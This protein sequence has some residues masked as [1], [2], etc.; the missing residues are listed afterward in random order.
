VDLFS[1]FV[2]NEHQVSRKII[3]VNV[4]LVNAL[5]LVGFDT[6]LMATV[7]VAYTLEKWSILGARQDI[8]NNG[9]ADKNLRLLQEGRHH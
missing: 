4:P 3:S 6:C 1:G 5:E 8:D 9:M 2:Y 7:D